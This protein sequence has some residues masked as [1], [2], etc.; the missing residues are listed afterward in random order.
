MA[1][2]LPVAAHLWVTWPSALAPGPP[3][4]LASNS[5]LKGFSS[6]IQVYFC[7]S[8]FH[9]KGREYLKEGVDSKVRC[10]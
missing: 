10:Y 5:P 8:D 4:T 7:F 2:S 1:A 3:K 9:S 6:N